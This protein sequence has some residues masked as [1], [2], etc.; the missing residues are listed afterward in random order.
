MKKLILI[1]GNAIVHRS[2]HAIPP[3]KTKEGELINAV[4]G[5]ISILLTILKDEKPDFIAVSFDTKAK[6]FRHEEYKEYKATRVKAP[7]DL[8]AQ[9][10]RIKEFLQTFKIPIYEKDGFEADDVLGTLAKE[11]KAHKDLNIYIVSGDMDNFQLIDD[12]VKVIAPKHGSRENIIYDVQK[13][14]AK[15]GIMPKQIPDLKGL[16]GDNSDNIKGVTGVGPKTAK[17][18]LQKYGTIENIYQHLDQ[19]EGK[20]HENLERDK[21]NA[22][23][24]KKM[25]TIICDVQ[26][27]FKLEDCETKKY[28]NTE[29]VKLMEKMEFFSLLKRFFAVD[30]HYAKLK[31]NSNNLQGSLF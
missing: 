19:I 8:Y 1:D 16:Q 5:F 17:D 3:F 10:P 20:V 12:R 14:L 22:F 28:N 31:E 4:Y 25:A 26:I 18:L 6:T 15:Y 11:A 21:E 13:V 27:N 24:S 2:Y 29:L 30:E 23:F 7:D 9:I